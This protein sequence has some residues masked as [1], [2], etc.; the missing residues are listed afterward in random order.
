MKLL[1]FLIAASTASAALT[2]DDQA[3]LHA[4]PILSS[5][6]AACHGED[7]ADIDGDLNL[8]SREGF[9][10]GGESID[11]LLIPGDAS[12]SFL[13]TVI[14]WED[15][16]YEM[17]PKENDRLDEE[18]IAHIETW[19]NNGAPWPSDDVQKEIRLAERTKTVTDE[20]M[21]VDHSGG[22]SDDWTYRRYQPEDI[23]A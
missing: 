18:Q 13:M 16:E 12:K 2:P 14:K 1:P 20:G 5:K 4:L 15:D 11:D 9:L 10:N 6:C 17:P 21:I 19:I 23:W 22:T 7:P 8:L 3:T